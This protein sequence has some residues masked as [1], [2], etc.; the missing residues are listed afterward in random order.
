ME[1]VIKRKRTECKTFDWK[2]NGDR[3]KLF[4]W[5]TKVSKSS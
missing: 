3:R 1:K 5:A 4:V 2:V